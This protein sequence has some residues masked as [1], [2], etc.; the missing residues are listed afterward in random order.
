MPKIKLAPFKP[1][2]HAIEITAAS[3]SLIT[4]LNNNTI[5][6]ITKKKTWFIFDTAWNSEFVPKIMP[7]R[8]MINTYDFYKHGPFVV[9]LKPMK[10]H[11]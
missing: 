6:P 10:N 1:E 11:G 2:L 4:L 3:R 7:Y 5:P 8:E 9:R